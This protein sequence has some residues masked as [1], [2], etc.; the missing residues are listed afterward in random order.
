M[1]GRNLEL[2]PREEDTRDK[3]KIPVVRFPLDKITEHFQENISAVRGQFEVA[4]ELVQ[5]GRTEEGE[6]IWR[7]QI[8][9]LESA[10][11]FFM[12]ELTKYGLC[13]IHAGNWN[14]TVK[15][16]NIMVRMGVVETAM[17]DRDSD[18]W[19]LD[20]IDDTYGTVTMASW[21]TVKDQISLLGMDVMQI[22]KDAFWEQGSS[23][24]PR[25]KMKR[26]L[27][28][29]FQRRNMIAHQS[30][31]RHADAQKEPISRET[32]EEFI[33]DVEKIVA[34]VVKEAERKQEA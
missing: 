31:R 9:F 7:S 20:F 32:V 34:A 12:H 26:R 6:N 13:E 5:G 8:V 21:D 14:S 23:E 18:A 1:A 27:N 33:A 3:A 29:L 24:K 11:D 19:F 25:D 4:E 22:A 2:R 10:L 17:R 30:D 28:S 16:E 15:Y